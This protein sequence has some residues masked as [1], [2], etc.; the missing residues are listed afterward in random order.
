MKTNEFVD[1]REETTSPAVAEQ[2][3]SHPMGF[4]KKEN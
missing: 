2:S 3:I 1:I 4:I